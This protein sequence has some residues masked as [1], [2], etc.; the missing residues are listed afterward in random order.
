MFPT[1][2]KSGP[3]KHGR[4]TLVAFYRRWWTPGRPRIV[5]SPDDYAWQYAC[6]RAR[7]MASDKK[8]INVLI[9]AKCRRYHNPISIRQ[10]AIQLLEKGAHNDY[11]AI[12]DASTVQRASAVPKETH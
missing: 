1:Q 4:Y 12:T 7:S 9:V 2:M 5:V 6:L 11:A 10:S 8:C 3:I